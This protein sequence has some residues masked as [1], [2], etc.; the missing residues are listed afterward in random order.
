MRLQSGS[1]TGFT[2]PRFDAAVGRAMEGSTMAGAPNGRASA[3]VKA[4]ADDA[5]ALVRAE[6][7]LAKAE[8]AQSVREK[9]LGGGLLTAAAVLAWLGAQA[10]LVAAGFALALVMPAWAAALV[11]AGALLLAGVVFALVGRRK[12]ATPVRID[13]TKTNIAEDLS[14]AKSH[15]PGR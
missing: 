3:A 14:W 8:I 7:A 2:G 10:L 13:T 15:L 5:S 1:R 12:V 9:A 11:V 4:V 6:I